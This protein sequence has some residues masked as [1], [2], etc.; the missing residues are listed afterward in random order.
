MQ[1][2]FNSDKSVTSASAL[3]GYSSPNEWLKLSRS[4]NTFTS[5]YSTD[6]VTWKL[7]GT[8]TVTMGTVATIGMFVNSHNINQLSTV[9]F[10]NVSVTTSTSGPVPPPWLSTDVGSP[11]LVGS[12]GYLNGVFTVNGAGIDIW[13]T[14]DQF[15]YVYQNITGNGTLIARV[16]SQTNSSSNAKA[17]IMFKQSTTAGDSYFMIAVAPGG[18][19]KVQYNF[20]GSVNGATYTFP[21]VWMKITRVGN[22]FTAYTSA[23]GVTWTQVFTK[24]LTMNASMTAG[25][26]ECSHNANVMGTATFDNVSFTP[27]P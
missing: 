4:G 19:I 9:A 18:G 14:Y 27:G 6:G 11:T 13:K 3:A 25:L 15:H 1:Y 20:T 5:W 23:D 12:A 22:V 2:N 8:T 26:F 16:S 7:V 21:N 10:D 17:G 24:T